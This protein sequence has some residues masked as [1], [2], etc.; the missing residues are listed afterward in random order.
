MKA[1]LILLLAALSM[2]AG[3]AGCAQAPRGVP[4]CGAIRIDRAGIAHPDTCYLSKEHG[5]IAV[6]VSDDTD[7]DREIKFV[8]ASPFQAPT[9]PLPKGRWADSGPITT[10]T[11]GNYD[12][13]VPVKSS[14]GSSPAGDPVIII[15]R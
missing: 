9:Y 2:I 1:R 14:G 3:A 10:T 6:W 12:Y 5:D 4:K 13:T 11:Y 8:K 15:T 7:N